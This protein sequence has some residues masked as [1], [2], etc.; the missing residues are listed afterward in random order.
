MKKSRLKIM[1]ICFL[2]A[3]LFL[4]IGT[5]SSF[6]YPLNEWMDANCFFTVGKGMFHG[7]VLYMDLFDQKGPLLFFYHAIASLISYRS[8]LG[9]FVIEVV[10]FTF[11]L[12]YFYQTCH[13]F[14]KKSLSICALPFISFIILTLPAFSHGDSAEELCLPFLM[15]SIYSLV[16]F[17][18]SKKDTPSYKMIFIN[19][20]M[21]GFVFTIK[22]SMLGFWFAFMMC[23]FFLMLKEKEIKKAFLSCFIFL[24]GMFVPVIPWIFY[25]L[26]NHAMDAFINSYLLFNVKYYVSTI[27]PLLKFFMVIDKPLR[28]ISR[29]LGIGLLLLTGAL[30]IFLDKKHFHK[31]EYK[32][33]IFMTYLF[34]C[35]GVFCGGVSFR[36]YYLILVP[37][38]VFGVIAL[39]SVLQKEY[40]FALKQNKE[41]IFIIVTSVFFALTFYGSP[42][43]HSIW[44]IG[45]K[46]DLVQ[47]KFAEVI[48]KE[49]DSTLLNYGFLD[50][51]FYTVTGKLPINRYF[52]KQNISD[53]VYPYITREQNRMIKH[54]EVDFVITRTPLNYFVPRKYP[55]HIRKNYTKRMDVN[56]TYEEKRFKYMLWEKKRA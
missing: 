50:G 53:S 23:L 19:G 54:R 9:V 42:N 38:S 25:F 17:F 28:F 27:S 6:L 12:Y 48:N 24:G 18:Q 2:T 56:V 35:I 41:A 10:S 55:P 36:Y 4:L 22:F 1:G 7:K 33:I 51:G 37:F 52:Q 5:K 13:L 26:W 43:T 46:K 30:F 39:G 14:L 15:Y 29:N 34:L 40:G 21:A 45:T 44:P 16:R 31:K 8:F 11:F 47:Y 20:L 49:K 3:F 32:I